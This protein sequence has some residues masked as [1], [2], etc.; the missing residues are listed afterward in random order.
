[1]NTTSANR[2]PACLTYTFAGVCRQL[3]LSSRQAR[4]LRAAGALLGPDVVVPGGGKKNELWTDGR[5]RLILE[6][7]A[8]PAL[9]SH[10]PA[11]HWR[12]EK[13]KMPSYVRLWLLIDRS[14]CVFERLITLPVDPY[15]SDTADKWERVPTWQ[16]KA[17]DLEKLLKSE[18]S[19]LTVDEKRAIPEAAWL[20]KRLEAVSEHFGE[21]VCAQNRTNAA[22]IWVINWKEGLVE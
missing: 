18:V 3:H 10:L 15:S 6:N 16:G 19:Q 20:G 13:Y 22:R 17:S 5:I 1:M 12:L 2:P 8:A 11:F 21:S 4:A 9:I 14:R 7:W